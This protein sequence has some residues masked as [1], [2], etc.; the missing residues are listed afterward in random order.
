MLRRLAATVKLRA[1]ATP[2]KALIAASLSMP[3][4]DQR[5][6]SCAATLKRS[7][8]VREALRA[9]ARVAP[10]VWVPAWA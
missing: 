9:K 8:A 2:T 3:D 4:R 7:T 6:S 1:S 5:A 10:K